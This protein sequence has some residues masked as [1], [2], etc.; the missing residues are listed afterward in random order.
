M[1]RAD[2]ARAF[3]PKWAR[4][5]SGAACAV[6]LVLGV[7]GCDEDEFDEAE[8]EEVRKVLQTGVDLDTDPY[9][10]AETLR[11]VGLI[12][13]PSL[14]HFAQKLVEDDSPMV[15][16]AALRVLLANDGQDIRR[17]TS[18]AFNRA[19]VEEKKAILR[20]VYEFGSP[21]LR[22]VITSRAL[23]SVDAELRALAFEFGP[24][25]RL[26]EALEEDKTVYLE[27]T[28]YP[29]L[30]RYVTEADE[31]LGPM[32]LEALVAAGQTDRAEPLIAELKDK[33]TDRDKRLAA[34]RIL[35]RA[36][37]EAA[38]PVFVDILKSLRVSKQ[39]EFVLPKRIDEELIRAATLGVVAGGN[40]KY[41]PQAQAYL[42]NA[43]VDESIEVLTALA[44]NPSK[45]AAIS[46]KIAMQDAREPVRTRAIALY[47]SN[48][49]ASADAFISAMRGTSFET[50]KLL[51]QHLAEAFPEAW[52]EHLADELS[53]AD[54]QEATLQLLR[55]V[56]LTEA[57]AAV[58]EP[59]EDQ[60][61]E[62]ASSG[63]EE[64]APL[65]A[66]LLVRTADDA[67]VR[68]LI[69]KEDNPQTRYAYLEHLV[70]TAPAESAEYF[71]KNFYSDLY[72]LRLMSAAGMLLAYDA[73]MGATKKEAPQEEAPE[74]SSGEES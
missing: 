54:K 73:G 40:T 48:P 63:D 16:V 1:S 9:V 29:E 36:R 26:D 22:R 3:W 44:S 11:V 64:I 17:T 66:L 34:A 49:N 62:I 68:E 55:D 24:L 70:R 18:G 58:L 43:G 35:G 31:T 10:Q 15:R 72:A 12:G 53:D 32:A 50:Q 59:L 60:L 8:R 4:R 33:S 20:A 5:L 61:Y 67:K 51:A 42:K 69:E 30:G 41:V 21:P 46:L 2:R 27:N 23:R 37:V 13:K 71:R 14:N 19:G 65:A 39:G 57:T 47:S 45:D 38:V 25:R 52:A 74:A 56:T 6:A 28:L 7:V